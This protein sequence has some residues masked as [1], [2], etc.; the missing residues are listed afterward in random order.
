VSL[1]QPLRIRLYS[2]K[3]VIIVEN[4]V[5]LKMDPEL[6]MKV[7]LNNISERYS[8]L[9]EKEIAIEADEKIFKVKLPVI[10]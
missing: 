1:E 7:G 6:S 4:D 3:G 2:E 8:H 10:Q 5:Q 9:L